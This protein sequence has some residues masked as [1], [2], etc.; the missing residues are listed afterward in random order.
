MSGIRRPSG[1]VAGL[2]LIVLSVLI[3]P[4]SFVARYVPQSS[5]S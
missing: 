4:E 5:S 2:G 1:T 3:I